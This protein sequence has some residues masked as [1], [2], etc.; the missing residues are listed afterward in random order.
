MRKLG[1]IGIVG[2]LVGCLAAV[3][4]CGSIS[5]DVGQDLP[6]QKVQGATVNPLQGLLPFF[7]QSGVPITVDLK[8]ETAKRNTGPASHAY[9]KDL[10]LAATPHNAPS[11]T[12][13]FLDEVHVFVES[14]NNGALPRVEIASVKPVPKG[15]ATLQFQIVDGVDLLPYFKLQD[16]DPNKKAAITS[17]ATGTQPMKDISF[18]GHIDITIKI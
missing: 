4:G 7:P 17:T 3:S 2:S 8:A 10:S 9:L 6:E 5:F 1:L 16:M 14:Q 12:F 13:D 11:G 15:Q 18:D